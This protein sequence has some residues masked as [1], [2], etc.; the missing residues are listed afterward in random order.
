MTK[1]GIVISRKT[2]LC[3][4]QNIKVDGKSILKPQVIIRADL[5]PIK[6]GKYC[7]VA[8]RSI[9]RP[10][11]RRFKGGIVIP[12]IA[13]G[14]HV[15]IGQDCVVSALSIGSFVHIG[16]GAVVSQRCILKDCCQI[17][18]GAIVP[19]DTVVPPYTYWAGV[20]ARLTR[21]LP[22]STEARMT[23]Y[24]SMLYKNF[25]LLEPAMPAKTPRSAAKPA[26]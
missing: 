2:V 17:A 12:K 10:P 7:V 21:E 19:P 22:D 8:E 20:P 1:S 16:D 9:V 11:C 4:P 24:T 26:P 18:P 23:D 15:Y 25:K 6:M 14:S 5:A 3:G 13:I